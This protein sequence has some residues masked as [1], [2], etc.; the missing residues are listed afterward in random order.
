MNVFT[1]SII[2][3]VIV[4]LLAAIYA[5]LGELKRELRAQAQDD[6]PIQG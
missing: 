3:S 4:G 6:R 1:W 5:R 2:V